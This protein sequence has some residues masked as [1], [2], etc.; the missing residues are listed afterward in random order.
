MLRRKN[1][2]FGTGSEK[3]LVQVVKTG[4]GT[5]K[6]TSIVPVAGGAIAGTEGAGT[7]EG[8]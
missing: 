1:S 6:M 7:Q 2:V 3:L 8:V 5:S 4:G